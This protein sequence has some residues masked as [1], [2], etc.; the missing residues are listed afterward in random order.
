[1]L[2]NKFKIAQSQS[3][4]NRILTLMDLLHQLM[5]MCQVLS[6]TKV[7]LD[8]PKDQL[9]CLVAQLHSSRQ[10]SS[11][12]RLDICF[13]VEAL[14]FLKDLPL[15]SWVQPP[16]L[17]QDSD[18][19]RK[20]TSTSR[21]NPATAPHTSLLEV[22]IRVLKDSSSQTSS[23]HISLIQLSIHLAHSMLVLLTDSIKAITAKLLLTAQPTIITLPQATQDN[24]KSQHGIKASPTNIRRHT[25]NKTTMAILT[26][27]V[28]TSMLDRHRI[29]TITRR[30]KFTDIKANIRTRSTTTSIEA[31]RLLAKLILLLLPISLS[32]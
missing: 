23:L 11:Q 19:I 27:A 5:P 18:L 22:H 7:C 17:S 30:N 10:T 25:S 20:P 1:M 16:S 8:L 4:S 12:I 24:S 14:A 3:L 31:I 6:C 9:P 29:A 32:T 2:L 13:S 28:H 15:H 26:V 21:I